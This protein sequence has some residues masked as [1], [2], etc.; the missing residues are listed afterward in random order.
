[1][2][3]GVALDAALSVALGMRELPM[4]RTYIVRYYWR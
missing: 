4:F 2:D 3:L 1:M